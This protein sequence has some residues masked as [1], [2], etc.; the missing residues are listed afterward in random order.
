MSRARGSIEIARPV[1]DVFAVVA[2]QRHEV[3]YN[4]R[5]HSSVKSSPGPIGVG[6]RFD[7][8]VLSRGRP[9]AV[10]IEYTAYDPPHR[11]SSRSV[12]A[13]ALVEGT[14]CCEPS[15]AGTRFSWDWQVSLP[16]WARIA[17]PVVGV[18]GRRQEMRIWSGLKRYL[19][20]GTGT[21]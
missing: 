20:D 7:A 1:Q 11:V 10:S 21:S 6:T 2:D 17:G 19:E 5:M 12:M 13:G 4:P 15:R 8:Q 16:G 18:I 9:L 14:V 3:H